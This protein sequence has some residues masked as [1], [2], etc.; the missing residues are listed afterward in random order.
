MTTITYT[1]APSDDLA[2]FFSNFPATIDSMTTP[3]GQTYVEVSDTATGTVTRY[4][5]T[6]LTFAGTTPTG[7]TVTS[8]TTL[9]SG[10]P[11]ISIT[12]VS[13]DFADL[14]L[15]SFDDSIY[16]APTNHHD[17]GIGATEMLGSG[18]ADQFFSDAGNDTIRADGGDDTIF[19]AETTTG[20]GRAMELDGGAG[21][22]DAIHATNL[23]ANFSSRVILTGSTLTGIEDLILDADT[24]VEMSGAAAMAGLS[25]TLNAASLLFV[26]QLDGVALNMN[27][28]FH[29]LTPA[30]GANVWVWGS[31]S[32]DSQL[33]R[34]GASFTLSGNN[35]ND[36]LR[37]ADMGDNIG[38]GE[39][40]DTLRGMAGDDTMNGW[41]GNDVY[42]ADST[43][44]NCLD[45]NV[46]GGG[47]DIV[48][49]TATFTLGANLEDLIAQGSAAI[50]LTG[51]GLSNIILG[52]SA[53]NVLK[54]G[55]GNDSIIGYQGADALWGGIGNDTLGGGSD[56]DADTL[57]G[58]VGDDTYV[59]Q[60][61]DLVVEASGEGN[62]TVTGSLSFT[63][64]ANIEVG[65]L[66]GTA[67]FTLSGNALDNELFGNG[68]NNRLTGGAG[69]DILRGL[70][71]NDT[72][73]GGAGNDRLVDTIGNDRFVFAN[74]SG[75]D[76]VQGFTGTG[77]GADRID[78]TNLTAVTSY[79]D[80]TTNHMAQVG[81]SVVITAGSDVLVLQ[82]VLLA[83]L[84]AAD[85]LI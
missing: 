85:F 23:D 29:G 83:Q 1:G 26:N 19:I 6:G 18:F 61:P 25:V 31:G 81:G 43:F 38:G 42:Y 62:D 21:S 80:L 41:L 44:D 27:T 37:G 58:G 76:T 16:S 49:S 24:V 28:F 8:I 82:G 2:F 60:S 46:T 65:L 13:L 67:N 66:G 71:G 15:A 3:P 32:D 40:N 72:L 63:L 36:S 33:G 14:S 20:G 11:Q 39:G 52:N 47:H 75:R 70:A 54:G 12:G 78:I 74:G 59:L 84:D 34:N 5:G 77:A 22:H 9:V 55:S 50:D 17:Q 51:N 79:A 35:G 69:L 53:A 73:D 64:A 68:G 7:G 45:T 57:R 48:Y 10:V 56:A 4:G 30:A